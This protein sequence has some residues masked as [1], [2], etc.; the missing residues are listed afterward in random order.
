M[1]LASN[2]K[3]QMAKR[4]QADAKLLAP[5]YAASLIADANGNP[6][7]Q[8]Q[9]PSNSNAIVAL[10]GIAPRSFSGFNIVAEISASAAE[11]LP[12]HEL[13]LAVKSTTAVDK[14]AKFTK[15]AASVATSSLKIV[16]TSA[17][18]ALADLAA[19]PALEMPNDLRNGFT[20]R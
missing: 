14:M 11:G 19:A 6:V 20:G 7:V 17:A 18:P 3:Q 4:L 2:Q 16:S 13:T 8:L 10:M 12:E 1:A 15:L 9:D 5:E